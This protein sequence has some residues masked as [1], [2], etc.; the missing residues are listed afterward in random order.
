MIT[1]AELHD[2]FNRALPDLKDEPTLPDFGASARNRGQA[3][4]RR[5][6]ITTGIGTLAAACLVTGA[7]LLPARLQWPAE[8]TSG[9]AAAG[10]VVPGPTAS[11]ITDDPGLAAAADAAQERL[12]EILDRRLPD[13]VES[14]EKDPGD[15]GPW[16]LL[17]LQKGRTL[18]LAATDQA[19][20]SF[21]GVPGQRGLCGLPPGLPG[22]PDVPGDTCERRTLPDGGKAVAARHTE[23]NS[24]IRFVW[25]SILTPEG[26]ARYLV[27][28]DIPAQ[29]S[30]RADPLTAEELFALAADR[31]VID[32]LNALIRSQR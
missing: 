20:R 15:V 12:R 9:P 24:G 13:A 32:G 29:G 8:R 31:E 4:H 1:E 14:V 22:G 19:V 18:S 25:V 27:C 23:P 16:Y 5:R 11:G 30:D 2:V 26:K 6:R 7:I 3:I 10:R 28:E 21:Y 17:R